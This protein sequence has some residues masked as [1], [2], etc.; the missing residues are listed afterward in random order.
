M[1]KGL[2]FNDAI[3]EIQNADASEEVVN[4]G[5]VDEST[6]NLDNDV[7]G[8]D[9]S[10]EN[11]DD[12]S[13][14]SVD[15]NADN[16][17]NDLDLDEGEDVDLDDEDSDDDDSDE[18]EDIFDLENWDDSDDD[19]SDQPDADTTPT[20][21]FESLAKELGTESIKDEASLKGYLSEMKSKVA[22]LE[23]QAK[24]L[25]KFKELPENLRDAVELAQE[26]GDY[27][28]YLGVNSI[29]YDAVDPVDLLV[30]DVMATFTNANGEV[31]EDSAYNYLDQLTEEE[32]VYR[33]NQL[34][35]SY[36]SK[37]EYQNAQ[38]KARVNQQKIAKTRR[39]KEAVDSLNEVSGLK[40]TNKHKSELFEAL[41]S[42]S[43]EKA[44]LGPKAKDPKALAE[45]IFKVR[46][47]DKLKQK[48]EQM[49]KT[50]TKRKILKDT[51]NSSVNRQGR[52]A[53][54]DS[55]PKSGIDAYLSQFNLK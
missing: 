42:G 28:D 25:E 27:L 53:E 29:N 50:S 43:V 17:N 10:D 44:I 41:N 19:D 20:M 18:L 36:K 9:G 21:D 3:R 38:I 6:D 31:D 12:V 33:G 2:S 45:A 16:D 14:S 40:L 48:A 32:K 26:G 7:D 24:Q 13:D 47:F 55:K 46:N 35:K 51:T 54:P 5:N 34:K 4:T 1:S 8:Q 49:A 15:D 30:D 37:Q 52:K 11:V 22:T 39:N 23:E